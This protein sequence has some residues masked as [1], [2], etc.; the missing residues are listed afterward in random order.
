MRR[1]A[2]DEGRKETVYEGVIIK[3]ANRGK[4]GEGVE[5]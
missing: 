5:R 3:K 4:N 1:T 2:G